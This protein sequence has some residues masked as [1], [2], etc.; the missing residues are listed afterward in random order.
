MSLTVQDK[1]LHDGDT[2]LF[3]LRVRWW[4]FW[5]WPLCLISIGAW[6]QA[7]CKGSPLGFFV[8]AAKL[9]HQ[10]GSWYALQQTSVGSKH[11]EPLF[12][13]IKRWPGKV[14]VYRPLWP[15]KTAAARGKHIRKAMNLQTWLCSRRYG[16]LNLIRCVPRFTPV[17]WRLLPADKDDAGWSRLPLFC[18]AAV[19]CTD[20][21]GGVDPVKSKPDRLTSPQDLSESK[22]YQ[23]I[24][25]LE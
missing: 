14:H 23:F 10:Y 24:C 16:W 22:Q 9:S 11:H 20:R 3:K 5:E 1:I 19:S 6:F 17:L 21:R 8:H 25:V 12:P 18:S 4:A 13:I 2:L 15:G 7:G